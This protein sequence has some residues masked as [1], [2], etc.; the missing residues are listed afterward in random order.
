M[1]PT[2]STQV[3]EVRRSSGKAATEEHHR[4]VECEKR[5]GRQ[6][7]CGLRTNPAAANQ[8]EGRA[9]LGGLL[10]SPPPVCGG[11]IRPAAHAA[12]RF[13]SPQYFRPHTLRGAGAEAP[14][15][16]CAPPVPRRA[17]GLGGPAP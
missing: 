12:A 2:N 9:F 5:G 7:K 3:T 11:R 13:A 17:L 15:Q 14:G 10:N 8:K 6:D 16:P 1:A 4:P